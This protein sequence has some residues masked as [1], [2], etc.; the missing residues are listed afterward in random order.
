MAWVDPAATRTA[1]ADPELLA[2]H[3]RTGGRQV[4]DG[5]HRHPLQRQLTTA[6]GTARR[7][8][9]RDDPVDVLGD[10]PVGVATVGRTWLAAWAP[11]VG[12]GV[13]LGDR[14]S[15]AFRRPTQCLDL[16]AQPLVELMEPLTLGPQPLV[17]RTQPFPLLLQQLLLFTQRAV[18]VLKP[19]DAPTQPAQASRFPTSL[20]TP[21]LPRHKA[22][23]LQPSHPAS[24]T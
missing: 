20:R 16:A 5:L 7:Q 15:L 24:R 18:L 8:P 4:L 17:L 3:Q 19:S 23:R 21:R 22:R 13:A 12:R 6:V 9:H 2:G 14:S 1:A 11:G 10:G